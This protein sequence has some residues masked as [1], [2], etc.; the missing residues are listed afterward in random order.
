M[1]KSL[2][3][4]EGYFQID[5][6]ASPGNSQVGEGKMFEAATITCEHCQRVLLRNPLRTRERFYCS[7][8]DGYVCDFCGDP[9]VTG[10]RNFQKLLDDL[11]EQAFRNLNIKET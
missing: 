9:V 1:S 6:T 11:Q 5:H 3:R 2:R 4:H 10:C 8:C 7:H